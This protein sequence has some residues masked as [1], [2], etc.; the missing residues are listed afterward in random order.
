MVNHNVDSFSFVDKTGPTVTTG[1]K[2]MQH[3]IWKA[4][5]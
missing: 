4:P 3:G 1:V 2:V 5:C